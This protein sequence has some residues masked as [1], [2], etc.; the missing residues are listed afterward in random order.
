MQVNEPVLYH[1]TKNGQDKWVNTT[2]VEVDCG[3]VNGKQT[4]KVQC[5]TE[6]VT[7]DKIRR[8]P[9]PT[10]AAEAADPTSTA[11]NTMEADTAA[12]GAGP[13]E[14][15]RAAAGAGTDEAARPAAGEGTGAPEAADATSMPVTNEAGTPAT[16][17][18]PD[19]AARAAAGVG[20]GA[21]QAADATSMADTRERG[22]PDPAFQEKVERF[23]RSFVKAEDVLKK[24]E[25]TC[26]TSADC[27]VVRDSLLR[28]F[29]KTSREGVCWLKFDSGPHGCMGVRV[30]NVHP[31]H[32]NFSPEAVIDFEPYMPDVIHAAREIITHGIDFVLYV[33][34]VAFALL[35]NSAKRDQD[36]SHG[37]RTTG[38]RATSIS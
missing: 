8:I 25:S 16:G 33:H 35:G 30:G 34:P 21:P 19:E 28:A 20:T 17:A 1:K 31:I 38:T 26:T 12:A 22:T 7:I 23:L 5:R 15:A 10:A 24:F 11:D 13:D 3:I 9:R 18:G 27:L 6:P 2:L 32:L 36:F 29:P 14:A 37:A 4:V